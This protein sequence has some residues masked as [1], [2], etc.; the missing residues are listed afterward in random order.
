MYLTYL[1]SFILYIEHNTC[2]QWCCLDT[3]IFMVAFGNRLH[4]YHIQYIMLL[5]IK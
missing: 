4:K 2:L 5:S 3:L 1:T